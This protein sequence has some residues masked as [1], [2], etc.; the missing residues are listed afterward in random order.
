MLK[1]WIMMTK[2]KAEDGRGGLERI[3]RDERPR[4]ER[5]PLGPI[6]REALPRIKPSG[7]LPLTRGPLPRIARGPRAR[8]IREARPRLEP[9][10]RLELEPRPQG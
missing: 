10:G 8:L 1:A 7:R 6:I 9:R 3:A 4:I 5:E 2:R